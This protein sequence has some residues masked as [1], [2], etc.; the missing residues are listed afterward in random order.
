MTT[1]SRVFEANRVGLS[2]TKM[3]MS[4]MLEVITMVR[5]P[6]ATFLVFLLLVDPLCFCVFLL[7]GIPSST[8][9]SNSLLSFSFSSSSSISSSSMTSTYSISLAA[10]YK[11]CNKRCPLSNPRAASP[12]SCIMYELA[13]VSNCSDECFPMTSPPSVPMPTGTRCNPSKSRVPR[14][15]RARAKDG[16]RLAMTP[17]SEIKFRLSRWRAMMN[18]I[19][20]SKSCPGSEISTMGT[21]SCAGFEV[22]VVDPA[23]LRLM[24]RARCAGCTDDPS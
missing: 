6:L 23:P 20:S 17:F 14:V 22:D 2:R 13:V 16:E 3:A 8:S 15:S 1:T 7:V 4:F 18:I 10:S 9:A 12:S 24:E 21:G 5:P 11:V 19:S